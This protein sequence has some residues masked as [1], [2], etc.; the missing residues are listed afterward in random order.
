MRR[1]RQAFLLVIMIIFISKAILSEI[2]EIAVCNT[3]IRHLFGHYLTYVRNEILVQIYCY[4]RSNINF[5]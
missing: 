4:Y 2:V 1:V 5:L 3:I